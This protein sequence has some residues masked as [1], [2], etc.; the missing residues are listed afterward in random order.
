[1]LQITLITHS[2]GTILNSQSSPAAAPWQVP[3]LAKAP[4]SA[5]A[6]EDAKAAAQPRALQG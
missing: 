6:L 5:E 2:P 1:M 4:P 3:K